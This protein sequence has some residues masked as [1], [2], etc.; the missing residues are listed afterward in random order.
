MLKVS[1]GL[2][3][4]VF[5]CILC[6]FVTFRIFVISSLLTLQENVPFVFLELWTLAWCRLLTVL[7]MRCFSMHFTLHDVYRKRVFCLWLW[8]L[9]RRCQEM[10]MWV[11]VLIVT[12]VTSSTIPKHVHVSICS[13][14]DAGYFLDDANTCS[15]EYMFCLWRW[16]L[17]RRC[18]DMFMW[19]YVLL[20]TL[21]TSSTMPIHVHVS[22]CSACDAGYFL[23]D[24]KTCSC[25][26]M[27]CLWLW[28]LPRRCQYNN[29]VHVNT[30]SACDGGYFP[31]DANTCSC[32]YMFCLWRWLLPRR[33]QY[34]FMWVCVLLVTLVTSST[35]PRHVLVSI[36]DCRYV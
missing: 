33:C 17:P 13:A 23:D 7:C 19:V 12:L 25:E 26:Y 31:D 35:M 3:N 28:L 16:L 5:R 18:Q 27:F 32:E 4:C 24:A 14:C 2:S 8:L 10:C 11:Y 15:C 34:M 1:F 22:I 36:S 9:P 29:Y 30:C 20:V 21:V 6:I